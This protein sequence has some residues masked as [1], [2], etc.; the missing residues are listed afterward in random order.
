M[1]L[2]LFALLP[3]VLACSLSAQRTASVCA[4][5]GDPNSCTT[6]DTS[7]IGSLRFEDYRV[8]N[9]D[10][11]LV[12]LNARRTILNQFP[13]ATL[14]SLCTANPDS[15]NIAN[16]PSVRAASVN[17]E[18]NERQTLSESGTLIEEVYIQ[19]TANNFL[20]GDGFFVSTMVFRV[21]RN[22]GS[23][24][25]Q[26][27]IDP[28]YLP[29]TVSIAAFDKPYVLGVDQSTAKLTFVTAPPTNTQLLRLYWGI[30]ANLASLLNA[31]T[32]YKITVPPPFGKPLF[33]TDEVRALA[34]GFQ[35]SVRDYGS[36]VLPPVAQVSCSADLN[37]PCPDLLSLQSSADTLSLYGT[38]FLAYRSSASAKMLAANLIAWSK[39]NSVRTTALDQGGSP[40]SSYALTSLL[41]PVA[42]FW[43]QLAQDPAIAPADRTAVNAW[44]T[45]LLATSAQAQRLSNY[46]GTL[47]ASVRMMDAI[48]RQDHGAF[49]ETVERYYIA[50]NQLREDGSIPEEAKR[51]P[52][53]LTYTNL[54]LNNLVQ[55]AESAS[56]QGYD[57]YSLTAGTRSL[58][59]AIQFFL[60]ASDTPALLTRYYE[61]NAGCN[62]LSTAPLDQSV[63]NIAP[64]AGNATSWMEIYLARFPKSPLA[65]RL[66]RK[67]GL[68]GFSKRPLYSYLSGANTS[69]LFFPRE[70]LTPINSPVFDIAG[71]NRQTAAA[72]SPFPQPLTVLLR[73]ADGSPLSNLPVNFSISGV[74]ATLEAATVITA[75][76][77]LASTRV[78]AGARSGSL[79]INASALGLPPVTFTAT[80]TG[81]DPKIA[82]GGLAGAGASVPAV[83][84][85]SRGAILSIYGSN[86]VPAGSGRR[87]NANEIVNG[88]LP[89]SLLGVC[90]YFDSTLAPMLDAYPSQLN[91]IVP[92]VNGSSAQVRVVRNCGTAGEVR[93]DP[94]SI[95]LDTASPEFFFSALN[96]DGA[97]P[98]AALDAVTNVLIG[99]SNLGA[100][101]TFRPIAR[102]GIVTVYMNGL[103]A[104]TPSNPPGAIPTGAAPLVSNPVIRLG[105]QTLAASDVLYAGVAPGLVIYQ[106]NFRIPQT[107][108]TGNVPVSVTLRGLSTPPGAF[109]AIAP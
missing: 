14:A 37:I 106:V 80:I 2:P 36:P 40:F 60:D 35:Q 103:G 27:T 104:S 38:D 75:A 74:P 78:T 109:L 95:A 67:I 54:A 52:C 57:L 98:V 100:P 5:N 63:F 71:G 85:G 43:P 22:R 33:T 8:T 102:G 50:L 19:T 18:V 39:A 101:G 3:V 25:I 96:P 31:N 13:P 65:D 82:S 10:A 41:K 24:L 48:S 28:A 11:L 32:I 93:S 17:A 86:F 97:N 9:P 89:T 7:R 105:D 47:S 72:N 68:T 108:A 81:N 73:A 76:S 62:L 56:T 12:N 83:R 21:S 69:C 16:A 55:L 107:A 34:T 58:H 53:S 64:A 20:L 4:A 45:P 88:Q 91:V 87:V 61:P 66:R 42:L 6:I 99:P 49:A 26:L 77:G 29:S 44:L 94:E 30:A 70:E 51:G 15:G 46:Y 79:T 84:S 23:N 59:T 92:N 90:V 1:R